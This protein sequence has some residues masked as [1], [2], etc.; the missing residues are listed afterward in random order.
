M[1]KEE[2][3]PKGEGVAKFD[4]TKNILKSIIVTCKGI[5]SSILD[6]KSQ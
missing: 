3:P 4:F 1:T 2:T 6:Y 5:I